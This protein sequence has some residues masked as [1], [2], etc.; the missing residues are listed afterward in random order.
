M[1]HSRRLAAGD[2]G[3]RRAR[4]RA[5]TNA[6]NVENGA[7]ALAAANGAAP[8]AVPELASAPMPGSAS[9]GSA[10]WLVCNTALAGFRAIAWPGDATAPQPLD[11]AALGVL[12]VGATD[13]V[14]IY[15]L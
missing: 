10:H 1:R 5:A 14:R 12:R 11:A 9:A 13:P 4:G 8:A 6:A 7:G 3:V 15:R 2:V